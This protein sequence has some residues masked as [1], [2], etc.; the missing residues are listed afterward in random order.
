MILA[1][2]ILFLLRTFLYLIARYL[3]ALIVGCLI[4]CV[5]SGRTLSAPLLPVIEGMSED[6]VP[7][8]SLEQAWQLAHEP[9][10][11]DGQ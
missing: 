10:F 1:R 5:V 9:Q 2:R 3:M 6:E 8:L 4:K 7:L 11:R